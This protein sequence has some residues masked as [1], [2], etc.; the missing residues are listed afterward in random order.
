MGVYSGLKA[1]G[2][3]RSFVTAVD[4]PLI[5]AELVCHLAACAPECDACVPRWKENVEPLCAVYS[6]RC[7]PAIEGVLDQRRIVSFFPL[8][9][10][11]FVEETAVK[12]FDPHGLS[13]FNVNTREEYDTLLSLHEA[14]D[15]GQPPG[16][17]QG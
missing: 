13:F 5:R 17:R 3:E 7:L 14:G 9:R 1:S 8:I 2:S 4:T 12:R 10:A 6:R 15:D 11:C 16:R